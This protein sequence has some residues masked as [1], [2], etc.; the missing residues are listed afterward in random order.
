[1]G[2]CCFLWMGWE[3]QVVCCCQ[4]ALW[5][6]FQSC[7]ELQSTQGEHRPWRML[8]WWDLRVVNWSLNIPFWTT[9]TQR[10]GKKLTRQ[11]MWFCFPPFWVKLY[12]FEDGNWAKL[13]SPQILP[14]RQNSKLQS[15]ISSKFKCIKFS[16]SEERLPSIP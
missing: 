4:E 8:N 1:M 10:W 9:E 13:L 2:F 11:A 16:Y 12:H 15:L 6:W 3:I 14:I 5:M 7:P